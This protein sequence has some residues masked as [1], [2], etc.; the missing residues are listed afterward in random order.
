MQLFAA[1]DIRDGK[2]VRLRQ[3]DFGEETIYSDD[4]VA[5]AVDFADQ[6]T[7]WLHVVDLDG[8][9]EGAPTNL[10][11]VEQIADVVSVPV[12]VGGGVRTADDALRWF[13]AGV[14][15][16]ILGT[17][18][19]SHPELAERLA[20]QHRIAVGLDTRDGKVATHGWT[21]RSDSD[22][23]DL[24]VHFDET[25]VEAI[26]VT[27]ISRDGMLTGPDIDG[28]DIVLSETKRIEVVASGGVSQL[29]DL[30]EL[31]SFGLS[32]LRIDGDCVFRYLAGAIVGK[33]LYEG[34]FT[35]SQAVEALAGIELYKA[36]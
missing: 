18:A 26:I 31:A 16:V 14:T 25:G 32:V 29:Q 15:R 34:R 2:C 12:Q 9:R 11:I 19:L 17:V 33:A 13:D 27:D 21:E 28:L 22:V 1:I 5:V 24:A 35:V 30:K 36:D 8:A 3:G 4:P 6:G 23:V 10:K 7:Q 20:S